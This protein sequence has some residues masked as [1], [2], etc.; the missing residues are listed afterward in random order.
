VVGGGASAG[1][2]PRVGTVSAFD[3]ER[4]LGEVRDDDGLE[5]GFHCSAIVDGSRT[6]EVGARVAYVVAASHRGLMEARSLVAL[7]PPR[8]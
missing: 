1:C 8:R 3:E 2:E 6:I 4:G 7:T 5:L